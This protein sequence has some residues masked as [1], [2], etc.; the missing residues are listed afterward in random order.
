MAARSV[1]DYLKAMGIRTPYED[2]TQ[3]QIKEKDSANPL[4]SYGF[5]SDQEVQQQQQQ[6]RAYEDY[7]QQQKDQQMQQ[8][9]MQMPPQRA[10]G[11]YLGKALAGV[12]SG[13]KG[14][15]QAQGAPSSPDAPTLS[16]F[17]DLASQVGPAQ[18]KI[19]LGNELLQ[20]GDQRG[21]AMIQDG[22]EETQKN[23]KAK[24][25]NEN[26]Q[27][28]IDDRKRKPN[29]TITV[30]AQGPDG[31]PMLKSM[32]VIGTGPDGKNIYK[33][34]GEAAK[35]STTVAKEGWG[36][37]K[38]EQGK[39]V[40]DFEKEMTGA[41]NRLD[42]FDRITNLANNAKSG[43]GFAEQLSGKA[44][45]LVQGFKGIYDIV[46][47]NLDNRSKANI[48][49]SNPVAKYQG[50]F[51]NLKGEAK[52]N[53]QLQALL[54]EQAYLKATANGQK[55]TDA[56][57]RNALTTM[58]ATLNDPEAFKALIQQ[59]REMTVDQ[60]NNMAKNSGGENGMSLGDKYKDRLAGINARRN[61][62]EDT[63]PVRLYKNGVPYDIPKDKVDQ[64]LN[65]GYTRGR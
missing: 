42:T 47:N 20:G 26:L 10:I 7:I 27:G 55:A 30:Q 41:E 51:D 3:A 62:N 18:A 32:E 13:H 6:R 37:T 57:V 53:A 46:G 35:G 38:S 49:S 5:T 65:K 28:Q 54:L 58:G 33:D 64:A 21:A 40:F 45:N 8:M 39:Q 23:N 63:G 44:S 36:G 43:P 11:H 19:M 9:L 15:Q 48:M 2:M 34:L 31:T 24:L 61:P 4:S 12:L 60:L 14:Q 59:N 52:T 17:S 50:V 25:D 29:P 16:R 22:Q 1:N 56:D